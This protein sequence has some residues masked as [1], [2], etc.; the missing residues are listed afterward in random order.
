MQF[1]MT[2]YQ[3]VIELVNLNVLKFLLP[4]CHKLSY[5]LKKYY[6][7]MKRCNYLFK[8]NH[9]KSILKFLFKR[10]SCSTLQLIHYCMGNKFINNR[11]EHY[12]IKQ[13]QDINNK[14][15]N[16]VF[17]IVIY[18]IQI[19]LHIFNIRYC[20]SLPKLVLTCVMCTRVRVSLSLTTI[21]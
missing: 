3:I 16:T 12:H 2:R 11:I 15:L 18:L 13:F 4:Q 1:L 17:F 10:N 19:Y 8:I 21:V 7:T 14:V 9:S 20:V 6:F 5:N